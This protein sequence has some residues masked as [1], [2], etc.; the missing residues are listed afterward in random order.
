MA[1]VDYGATA[2]ELLELYR[3]YEWWDDRE[4]FDVRRALRSTDEVVLLRAGREQDESEP[5]ATARILTDYV[6][7]AMVYDVIVAADRRGTGVGRE[8]LT[9][10][11]EHP[12][13]QEVS[14]SLLAREGLVPFYE[15]CGF[16]VADEAVDHPD[17]EPE[18]L[19]WMVH[20]R[21]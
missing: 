18:P 5:V 1:T 4:E 17:G 20:G 11:R 10:V 15:S 13:L 9:A 6:Y 14:P 3:E 8:L 19:V 16:D 7:Y 12:R 21:E 2:E